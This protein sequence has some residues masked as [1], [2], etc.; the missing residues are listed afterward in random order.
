MKRFLLFIFV[1][2][3]AF[4]TLS[5]SAFAF[6]CPDGG[7]TITMKMKAVEAA[8]KSPCPMMAGMMMDDNTSPVD[9]DS[10]Q[11]PCDGLCMCMHVF[12]AQTLYTPE[13]IGLFVPAPQ[14]AKWL[15]SADTLA[16]RTIVPP[17]RPPKRLS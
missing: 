17:R 3:F 16:S 14:A 11:S 15:A 9:D 10:Q 8:D 1:V 13:M 5:L 12:H 7:D 6:D 2:V 4:N